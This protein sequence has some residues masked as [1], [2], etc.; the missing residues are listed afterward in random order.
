[1]PQWG[2]KGLNGG[3]AC[4]TPEVSDDGGDAREKDSQR[5]HHHHVSHSDSSLSPSFLPP[6]QT[7]NIVLAFFQRM[8]NKKR[9]KEK[10]SLVDIYFVSFP[11]RLDC[12]F[13]RILPPFH[14]Y[15][16]SI[17][18][19]VSNLF[20]PSFPEIYCN[21]FELRVACL[22]FSRAASFKKIA[23]FLSLSPPFSNWLRNVSHSFRLKEI[24]LLV[25]LLPHTSLG[26]TGK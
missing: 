22:T 21:G 7:Q 24:S 8:S 17:F 20:P 18:T 9:K 16:T 2:K 10:W 19:A 4:S 3:T 11:I 15:T 26:R 25:V 12:V 5:H 13:G 6:T 23:L 1:M 14:L